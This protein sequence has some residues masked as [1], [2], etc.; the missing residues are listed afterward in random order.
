MD[1]QFISYDLLSYAME[2]MQSLSFISDYYE[3]VYVI[4]IISFK[5]QNC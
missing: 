5:E 2:T 3:A 1:H 4:L